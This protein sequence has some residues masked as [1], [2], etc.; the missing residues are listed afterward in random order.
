MDLTHIYERTVDP[1]GGDS[2]ARIARQI[3]P[4]SVVLELGPATGY[5]TRHLNESL[6]CTVDCIEYS[7]EMAD[8]AR[9]FARSLHVGDLDQVELADYFKAGE[10]DYVVAADVL[11]HLKNPWRVLRACRDLLK[12]TGAALLSIPNIAHAALIAELIAGRFEYRDEGLLDRTHLKFFTRSNIIDMLDRAGFRPESIDRIE[13]MAEQTEFNRVLED[14]PP[15]LR[16]YLLAH[17]DAL[18]YQFIVHATPGEMSAEER[19]RAIDEGRGP[20]EP[21]FL[22]KLY[23]AA[24]DEGMN[25]DKCIVRPFPLRDGPTRIQFDLPVDAAFNKLR[26][27]PADRPGF[28]RIQRLRL[29]ET[30]P[31]GAVGATLVDCHDCRQIASVFSLDDLVASDSVLS[32][33]FIALTNDPKLFY[34]LE[35]DARPAPGARYRLDVQMG[36]PVSADYVVAESVYGGRIRELETRNE[37]LQARIDELTERVEDALRLNDQ[38]RHERDEAAMYEPRFAQQEARTRELER[39]LSEIYDSKAWNAISRW[40]KFKGGLFGR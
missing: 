26:F 34:S 22:A 19:Q 21:Y 24:G 11:E 38:I 10:Y 37:A 5:F 29:Y 12:P 30:D 25:E 15:Q 4:G 33:A 9:P 32:D 14:L 6:G 27:D 13:W 20:A 18:T 36:W 17:G 7:P 39:V 8:L 35:S 31:D 16:H 1:E 3:R 2:L 23:W 28:L 40:R